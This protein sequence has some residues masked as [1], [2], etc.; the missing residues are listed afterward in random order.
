MNAPELNAENYTWFNSKPLSLKELR[1]KVILL[2]FWTYS[3]VNCLR[4]IPYL[5]E[6]SEKYAKNGFIVI[7]VH[8]PEFDFEKD[9][10]NV[11]RFINENKIKYPVVMDN[12]YTIWNSY[13]N[14]YWPTEYLIS[15]EG[16]IVYNHFGE[17]EY[18]ETEKTIQAL[19]DLEDEKI[20]E[21][22]AEIIPEGACFPTT[23]ELYAGFSQ[24]G[25]RNKVTKDAMTAYVQPKILFREGFYLNGDWEVAQ[26]R[27][28]H[29]D[30]NEDFISLKYS[31][32]EVNAVMG[33]ANKDYTFQVELDNKP[34]PKELWGSDIFA[35]EN[36]TMV[37]I[38]ESR[39]YNLIKSNLFSNGI[40]KLTTNSPD[41]ELYSFT[42]N[43]CAS[44]AA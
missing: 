36:G 32:F 41:L 13:A 11:E 28:K 38:T 12:D 17:G 20:S 5:K 43:S 25:P 10:K 44:S 4:T 14:H 34:I 2:D 9:A 23:P 39:L 31:S 18:A 27:I 30:T 15:Q 37:K 3:C 35:G 16:N 21:L 29:I 26:D 8:S 6:W 22:A 42:F 1:G 19:F 33:H 24:G 40:L 7:G